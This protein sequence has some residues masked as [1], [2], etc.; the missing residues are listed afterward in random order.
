MRAIGVASPIK[1]HEEKDATT[2]TTTTTTSAARA[3]DPRQGSD[4]VKTFTMRI[5]PSQRYYEHK[6]NIRLS[7][8]H[9]PWPKADSPQT[10]REDRDF[11]FLALKDVVPNTIAHA[12][13]CDW[14]T[15]GQLSGEP[16]SLRAQAANARLWHIK[17]RQERKKNRSA[18]KG[19]QAQLG[20][21]LTAIKSLDAFFGATNGARQQGQ[22]QS[23]A[24]LENG[25]QAGP[26]QKAGS[27]LP[28]SKLPAWLRRRQFRL[29]PLADRTHSTIIKKEG[30]MGKDFG[31]KSVFNKQAEA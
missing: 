22:E 23:P 16:V 11:V 2:S 21:D 19:L 17:E 20:G 28:P 8:T 12:G 24:G 30:V 9:G 26:T 6:K 3:P 14:H 15:G 31:W 1:L 13:L 10:R 25:V 18:G 29:N 5:N 4:I 7:P 27:P